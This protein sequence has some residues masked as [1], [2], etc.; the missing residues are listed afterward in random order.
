[1]RV[2]T[3]RS[4]WRAVRGGVVPRRKVQSRAEVLLKTMMGMI[5]GTEL[6]GGPVL[7]AA[8]VFGGVEITQSPMACGLW[9][10]G[11]AVVGAWLSVRFL[12]RFSRDRGRVA[13]FLIDPRQVRSSLGFGDHWMR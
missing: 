1:M 2:Q 3:V 10:A 13:D 4:K 5:V 6:I 7:L 11:A 12:P 9:M 8:S